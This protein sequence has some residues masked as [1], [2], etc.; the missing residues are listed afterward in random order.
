MKKIITLILVLTLAFTMI[1]C[2]KN[3]ESSNEDL[4]KPL[5]TDLVDLLPKETFKWAYGGQND[6]YHEMTLD[7]IDATETKSV[8]TI[9]GAVKATVAGV[10]TSDY[11]INLTYV[12]QGDSIKQIKDA[13]RMLDSEYDEITLIKAPLE[14]GNSW[15]EKI[16]DKKGKTQTIKS[17]ITKVDESEDGRYYEV[18]YKN[19]K[20]DYVEIRR[21]LTGHGVVAF[22]KQISVNGKPIQ[23]QYVLYGRNSGY[24]DGGQENAGET[25]DEEGQAPDTEE[26]PDTGETG[27]NTDTPDTGDNSNT[28]DSTGSEDTGSQDND[29]GQTGSETGSDKDESFEVEKAIIA[30]NNAWIEYVNNNDQSFFNHVITNGVAYNNA[31][32]FDRTG[33]KETFLNMDIS[34]V[35]VTGN[36]ATAHV[37]EEIKKEKNGEVSISKYNWLYDLIKKDGRWYINGYKFQ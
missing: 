32:K 20:N 3:D 1:A 35:K 10:D 7:T 4:N 8:Y 28:G 34:N 24:P 21:I 30:F 16:V 22:S 29:S 27:D 19:T 31:K 17:S 2:G 36:S 33:L 9:T 26:T 13:D 5:N 6:Y 25:P 23:Y 12:I 15:T 14:E 11:N 37:Y 18:L